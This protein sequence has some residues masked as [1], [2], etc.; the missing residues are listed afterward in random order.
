M[1][2]G[3]RIKIFPNEEQKNMMHKS[4]G[5]SR[6]IYNWCIDEIQNNYD[7][8]KKV[9]SAFDLQKKITVLKQQKEYDWLNEVSAN[10]LKQVTIDCSSAYKKWF[11]HIKK[12]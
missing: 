8:N 7:Q 6:F 11:K 5:C 3:Y 2:I 9:F 12:N 4:F 10:M 1:I